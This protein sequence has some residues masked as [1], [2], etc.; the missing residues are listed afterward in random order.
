MGNK[1]G[2][3]TV[4]T[5]ED[6]VVPGPV[7]VGRS[8]P[9]KSLP[10]D[11]LSFEKQ[12]FT[13][14]AVAKASLSVDRGAVSNTDVSKYADIAPNSVSNCNNFWLDAGLIVRDG[15][16]I[17]PV[18][19][20]FEYDQAA[21]WTPEIA[22]NKL[23]PVLG[24]SWFGKAMLTKLAMKDIS[25]SDALVFLAQ[26]CNAPIEYKGQVSLL[27]DYLQ[28][29]GLITM[30]GSTVSMVKRGDTPPPT[31]APTVAPLNP[32]GTSSTGSTEGR[33]HVQHGMRRVTIALPTHDD[34]TIEFP[35][36]L[37]SDDWILVADQLATY[38]KRWKQ[39]Q[40]TAALKEATKDE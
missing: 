2:S 36:A 5:G 25:I 22:F 34:V 27:L 21:E 39:W 18:D 7:K 15:L 38:I 4:T 20:V 1:S 24:A 29:A 33:R 10:T 16:K 3:E 12:K 9:T 8:K 26:E 14:R 31:P 23:A 32:A 35:D 13:L 19:A 30:D 40:A 17:R 28:A 37:D 6:P 11:R